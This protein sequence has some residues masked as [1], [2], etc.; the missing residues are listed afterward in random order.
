MRRCVADLEGDGLYE[1]VTRIWCG[2][3]IDIQTKEVFEFRPHEIPEMLKFMDTCSHLCFHNG[4]GYDF[5]ALEK[6][7]GWKYKGKKLDTL[8]LSRLLFPD[9]VSPKGIRAGP[10]SVESWGATFG[11]PKPEN[12]DWSKFTEHMLHRCSEDTH[13]QLELYYRCME[14]AKAQKW[15]KQAFDMSHK[16]FDI[17]GKQERSGWTVSIPRIQKGINVLERYIRRIDSTLEPQLPYVLDLPYKDTYVKKP[18]KQD[19]TLSSIACKWFPE[20]Q[21]QVSVSGPFTRVL[22]RQVNLNSPQELKEF[23]LDEGWQPEE[24]NIKKDKSGKPEKDSKGNFIRTSPKLHGDDPFIGLD[25]GIGVLAAKR[26][27]A[28]HRKSNLEGWLRSVRPDGRISQRITGIAATGRLTHSGIVN[29]PGNEAFFGKRMRSCFTA[30]KGYVLVGTDSASCQDRMLLGRATAYGVN[31]PVFEDMLLNGNKKLGTDSH[32]RAKNAINEVLRG[33]KL[34]EITRSSAKNFNYAYKFNA[35]DKK[36]GSMA[37]TNQK[38]WNP[39]GADIRKAL[40]DIFTAQVGVQD[41]LVQ[42]WKKT[43]HPYLNNWGRPDFKNGVIRGLDGRPVRILKQKDVLVYALQSDEAI[44]MQTALCFLYM[45]LNKRGLVYDK[46][47]WFCANVHDEYQAC[48]REEVKDIYVPLANKSI[49]HAGTFL[50]IQC[51]HIGESDI[52]LDWSQTH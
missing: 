6:V 21:D 30:P 7:H 17:M 23:L 27:Q 32:T 16:F 44:M 36:L 15:P 12:E 31:D 25:S 35:Q 3:F 33:W 43:A 5:P 11:R 52:G 4:Y 29:V 46:D 8:V 47:Y 45:W 22:F 39:L 28:R 24:W 51:Q 41:H 19:R 38:M 26:I 1:D 50:G 9:R 40:D 2:V 42:Q 18:F 34:P 10:H 20:E 13:I 37:V 48:V 14:K 49:S